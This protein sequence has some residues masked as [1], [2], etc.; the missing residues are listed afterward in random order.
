LFFY[1]RIVL[2]G[3]D[4]GGIG[5]E[6]IFKAMKMSNTKTP[7]ALI[8]TQEIIN[9]PLINPFLKWCTVVKDL[10]T[11][12][13]INTKEPVIIALEEKDKMNVGKPSKENGKLSIKFLTS[14]L[15]GLKSGL[16]CA[17]VTGPIS[18]TSWHL[19]EII[20]TGHTSFLKDAT[21]SAHVSMAFYSQYFKTILSTI[22]VPLSKV[23]TLLNETLLNQTLKHAIDYAHLLKI[24]N[25]RFALAGLNPHAG[26]NG[27]FGTEEETLLKPFVEK[28]NH[29]AL[30][31]PISPDTLY[32]R[33]I[34]KEWDIV[35]SLYHDQALMPLKAVDFDHAVNITIGLPFIRTSPD[36]GTAFEKAY[37]GISSPYSTIA[38]LE[39][40]DQLCTN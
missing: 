11:L 8:V 28:N 6:V 40:A 1:K 32:H 5:P 14:A 26:E 36:H 30:E 3:G 24:E 2:T 33:A 12:A 4:P 27:L 20:Q 19:A 18:K 21:K 23:P 37:Q 29:V 15:E 25:P 31:G 13:E 34:Q 35:I 39:L 9:H 7:I 22:H 16:F 17:L 38:A 10:S